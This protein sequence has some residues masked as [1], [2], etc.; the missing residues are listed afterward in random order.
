M[1]DFFGYFILMIFIII[2]VYLNSPSYNKF[3]NNHE[4]AV[5]KLSRT[6][7]KIPVDILEAKFSEIKNLEAKFLRKRE[8]LRRGCSIIRSLDEMSRNGT[9]FDDLLRMH[10]NVQNTTAPLPTDSRTCFRVR[11]NVIVSYNCVY[12]LFEKSDLFPIITPHLLFLYFFFCMFFCSL[13]TFFGTL[14]SYPSMQEANNNMMIYQLHGGQYQRLENLSQT[15][16]PFSLFYFSFSNSQQK[17][18]YTV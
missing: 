5:D 16:H 6:T 3:M 4:R 12:F 10:Q 15:I 2:N 9:S 17:G 13:Y 8:I 18:T 11:K 14:T 7:T 1:S